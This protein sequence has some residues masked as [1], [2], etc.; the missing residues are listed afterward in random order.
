M[1]RRIK[2][3]VQVHEPKVA[4]ADLR[5]TQE[6][7]LE[8]GRNPLFDAKHSPNWCWRC[9]A[10]MGHEQKTAGAC[11]DYGV[12]LLR[13]RF[14]ERGAAAHLEEFWRRERR[15]CLRWGRRR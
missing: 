4:A 12:L 3:L 15:W 7:G 5:F 13:L 14:G 11:E 6:L 2:R 8:K 1:G 9:F 10:V